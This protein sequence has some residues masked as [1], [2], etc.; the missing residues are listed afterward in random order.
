MT[1]ARA[2]IDSLKISPDSLDATALVAYYIDD[3]FEILVKGDGCIAF[4]LEDGRILVSNFEFP[5]GFPFYM[6]Y[7]PKYTL[8]FQQWLEEQIPT[9]PCIVTSSIINIDGTYEQLDDHCS[10]DFTFREN[11]KSSI[12]SVR[13][14]KYGGS[15]Y[16]WTEKTKPPK[17]VVLMSDG[18]N[19]FYKTVDS[20]TSLTNSNI[21]YREVIYRAL[22]FKNFNGKFMQRK[23][24]RF[25]KF[26]IKNNWH[27]SDDISF[28]AM[29]FGD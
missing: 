19:S 16:F 24:N 5:N 10:P 28:G 27:H 20:G 17:F 23:L 2:S 21:D 12:I 13:K 8:R 6:N 3:F 9:T 22:S 15:A 26:C 11:K 18:I 14:D 29:Y 25:L 1:K 4:G 7:L